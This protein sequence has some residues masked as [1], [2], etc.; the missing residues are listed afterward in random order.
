MD[1]DTLKLNDDDYRK[2]TTASLSETQ[3]VCEL[4]SPLEEAAFLS[5]PCICDDSS[6]AHFV[7]D[8]VDEMALACVDPIYIS[9]TKAVTE[10]NIIVKDYG[11]SGTT[12]ELWGSFEATKA[13]TEAN[14]IVK[15]YGRSGT[16]LELWGS[17]EAVRK[18]FISVVLRL[19]RHNFKLSSE[20]LAS[21][22]YE[23]I[24]PARASF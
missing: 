23:P 19:R 16:T 24:D 7:K 15:D 17:F 12:L 10:A 18:A 2:S 3:L 11:R 8:V 5:F 13:V 6:G 9:K 21:G 20:E 22:V 1:G 4:H 14:I